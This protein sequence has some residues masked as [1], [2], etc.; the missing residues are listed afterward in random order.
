MS[1]PKLNEVFKTSGI[2]TYTFVEPSEYRRI[3]LSLMSPGRGMVI[4]GPSG[5]GKTCS[6]IKALDS[7]NMGDITA[8][9]SARNSRDVKRIQELIGKRD[10]G[11]ILIDDFHKLSLEIKEDIANYLKTLADEE[12]Q[13][14]KIVIVGINRAGDSLIKLATD[15][16]NRIDVIKFETNPHDK[17]MELLEKGEKALNIQIDN[18]KEI[19]GESHGSFYLAQM[20]AQEICLNAN[21]MEK[22]EDLTSVSISLE[23]VKQKVQENLSRSFLEI[24]KKFATGP[25]L[26]KAGRAPYLHS[27]NWLANSDSWSISVDDELRR[28]PDAKPS[29]GQIVE[30]GYLQKFIEDNEEFSRVL[31]FDE[32]SNTLTIEDPQYI[33]YL[34]NILWSKFAKSLGFNTIFF[35][36]PYDFALSF[37]G[38]DRK[39]A[40]KI[41]EEL[42]DLEFNVFYDE[43]EQHRILGRNVE[44]YLAPIYKSEATFVIC[45]LSPDYPKR[46]WTK[47]ES[48]QFKDRFGTASVLP[49][50]F[51]NATIGILDPMNEVGGLSFDPSKDID[52]QVKKIVHLLE[53]KMRDEIKINEP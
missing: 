26:K 36:S 17:V 13:D 21:I 28:H 12:A 18:K 5:I 27:L 19:V 32:L 15:L 41:F 43:N 51:E 30:K 31:H 29:V 46:V 45:L 22:C 20:L 8:K 47:I 6:A 2:P 24:T 34:R 9:L 14:T 3:I 23:V 49:I 16:V 37:A 38:P 48:E 50:R 1:V 33:F 4:E 40:K 35:K 53:K 7:L 25:R 42:T 44:D 52:S 11:I 39:I 10:L